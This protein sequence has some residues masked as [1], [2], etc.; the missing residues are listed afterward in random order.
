MGPRTRTRQAASSMAVFAG[1][2][3]SATLA[4]AHR[5]GIYN[6]GARDACV[7]QELGDACSWEDTQHARYIGT[8]RMVST[9]LLCVRTQPIERPA[10]AAVSE[11]SGHYAEHGHGHDDDP[12]THGP[13]GHHHGPHHDRPE[14]DP[15]GVAS[16][17]ASTLDRWG[18]L[19]VMTGGLLIFFGI[20]WRAGRRKPNG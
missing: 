15:Q 17:P 16:G 8:C 9:A 7:E 13:S 14:H 3:L 11:S 18:P 12:H 4:H 2:M 1:V 20:P 5:G 19:L 6:R 10:D